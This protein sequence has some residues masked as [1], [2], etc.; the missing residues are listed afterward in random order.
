MQSASVLQIVSV[1]KAE[2]IAF[3]LLVIETY[4]DQATVTGSCGYIRARTDA[5]IRLASVWSEAW[6]DSK[7]WPPKVW[8]E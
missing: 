2:V 7:R 3:W 8:T 6:F 1:Y 5:A 4:T